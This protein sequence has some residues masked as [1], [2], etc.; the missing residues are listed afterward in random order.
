MIGAVR[1]LALIVE[2]GP[3]VAAR[4]AQQHHTPDRFLFEHEVFHD[5]PHNIAPRERYCKLKAA[6][7]RSET[8]EAV[9]FGKKT[10]N[11]LR[12]VVCYNDVLFCPHFRV[13]AEEASF[14]KNKR[15]KNGNGDGRKRRILPCRRFGRPLPGKR[16]KHK[17]RTLG[18]CLRNCKACW[19]RSTATGS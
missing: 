14:F 15:R 19:K 9:F 5:P 11:F 12:M 2:E 4:A 3:G 13:A 1:G 6:I 16:R 18:L 10:C 7:C 17:E 8:Q